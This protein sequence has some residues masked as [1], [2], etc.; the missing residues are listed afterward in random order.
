MSETFHEFVVQR[1][2]ALSRTAYLLTGDHQLAEDLLQS[3]LARTYRHWR[4]IRG[5]D[6]EAYVRRAMYHQQVSWWRRRRV[7]ERLAPE[8]VERGGGDHADTTALRLSLVDALRRLT[9]R[10]RAVV[11]LRFYE[12]LTEA[13]VAEALGCSL[14]TVKRHGHEALRRLRD[15]V[16]DLVERLPE[17]SAR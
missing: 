15:F 7:V 16:P 11:V 9:A 14:G 12:D 1:S 2:A 6:P 4:R 10:Q 17:R 8:P 5:G 13:Q 3:A